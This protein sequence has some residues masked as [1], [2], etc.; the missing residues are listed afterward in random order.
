MA[1]GLDTGALL[2][3]VRARADAAGVFGPTRIEPGRLVCPA[4]NPAEPAEYRVSTDPSARVW[5]ELVTSNRWLSESIETQLVHTGDKLNEL[6]DEELA[7]LAWV[8]PPSSFEHF[9][10]DDLLFT[11]RS[12]VPD[13]T[14]DAVSTWLLAYEQCFRQ[15]GDMDDSGGED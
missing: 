4:L 10:S 1:T 9:R 14:P 2:Q 5:V 6:L 11:F 12:R 8:G 15:L 7:D 13:A 3:R